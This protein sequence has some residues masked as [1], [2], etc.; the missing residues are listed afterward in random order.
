MRQT[1]AD[2]LRAEAGLLVGR[3]IEIGRA[4]T[5]LDGQGEGPSVL[6]VHGPGGVGKTAYLREIERM[7][8]AEQLPTT[9]LD[10][11]D[12]GGSSAG[13]VEALVEALGACRLEDLVEVV[14]PRSVTLIDRFEVMAGLERWFWTALLPALPA[15]AL[16]FVGSRH[17]PR[18]VDDRLLVSGIVEVLPLRNLGPDESAGL[19]RSRGV[20]AEADVTATVRQTYGH[21]LALVIAAD[22]WVSSRLGPPAEPG[23]R[24]TLL[25]HPD[26]AARL[27]GRFVD[28]VQDPLQ[29]DALH[30]AGHARRVD[31]V[32]LREVLGVDSAMA[33]DLLGWLRERPF[34]EAHPDGLGLHDIVRDALDQDLRWRDPDAYEALHAAIRS[35]VVGRLRRGED[36]TRQRAAADLLF[37]HRGNPATRAMYDYDDLGRCAI[38]PARDDDHTTVLDVVSR[39]E[40]RERAETLRGWLAA[41]PDA[42]HVLEDAAGGLLGVALSIRLDTDPVQRS[43]DPVSAA[44]WELIATRRPPEPGEKV[45]HQGAVDARHPDGIRSVTDLI[46]V[47]SLLTWS[48]PGLGWVVMASAQVGA[49]KR[50]WEYI[51]FEELGRVTLSDDTVVSI[52]GRDFA[53]SPYDVWLE[54]MARREIDDSGTM[55][56]PVAA[57]I[58]WS[59]TDFADHVRAALRDLNRPDRLGDSPLTA[60]EPRRCHSPGLDRGRPAP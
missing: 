35:V 57:P 31:R 3:D 17:V 7:A 29:R 25:G 47:H 51:G 22:N 14:P 41:Q 38:R 39:V 20:P 11:A 32:L 27:L 19:L 33:D 2:R 48:E 40:G 16:V 34:A 43:R 60:S 42:F 24:S 56:G 5:M 23:T 10:C 36:R 13:M 15:D 46:A 8:A 54:E 53:R 4:R 28:D 55:P 50:I 30:I 59:R 58:A 45:I 44:A 18:D 6:H 37:L 12:V 1:V 21:P 49:W 9:W 52:W 26:P